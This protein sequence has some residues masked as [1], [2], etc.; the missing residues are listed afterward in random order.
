MVTKV[1]IKDNKKSPVGYISSLKNFKNGNSFVF[2]DG[3]NVI[4]GENGSGKTTLMKLIESYLLVGYTQCE[5][6][7]FN[8]NVSRVMVYGKECLDGVDVYADYTR[9]T[10]RLCHSG[11]RSDE[12]AMLNKHDFAELVEQKSSSTGEGVVVALN[13]L[14]GYMFGKDAQ[15]TFDYEQFKDGWAIPYY[16]Y[17]CQ[18]KVECANEYTILMDEPDRNLSL[19]N[20]EHI[21]AILSFHKPQTQVIAVIHNPLIIYAIRNN[22]N[23]HFVEMTKGY[24]NKVVKVINKIVKH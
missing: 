20:I 24:V 18:H 8:S 3:V 22:E 11:E 23:V 19:D 12:E 9:N 16:D 4:V 7:M 2:K 13:S 21:K 15:L 14:F 17:V 10:F 5:R 1:V 6:G